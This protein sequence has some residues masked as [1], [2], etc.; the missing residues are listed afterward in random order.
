MNQP[1]M[2]TSFSA[3]VSQESESFRVLVKNFPTIK[4]RFLANIAKQGR[5][6][7]K[8]MMTGRSGTI[9]LNKDKG[10]KGKRTITAKVFIRSSSIKFASFPAN[11]FERGRRNP[12]HGFNSG[13]S[14]RTGQ[15]SAITQKGMMFITST[16]KGVASTKLQGWANQAE[17]DIIESATDRV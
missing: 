8:G 1:K 15:K 6:T 12:R 10:S 7:M 3:S 9:D 16:F 14:G 5:L 13:P 4:N 17:K 11:L 2:S